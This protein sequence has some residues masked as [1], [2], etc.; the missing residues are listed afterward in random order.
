[1]RIGSMALATLV[2]ALGCGE[3]FSGGTG[4]SRGGTSGDGGQGGEGG[5]RAV[6]GDGVIQGGEECDDQN[7]DLGDGCEDCDV[8]C[9]GDNGNSFE[10]PTTH[11]CY[12]RLLSAYQW[13]PANTECTQDGGKLASLATQDEYNEI[14]ASGLTLAAW[15]GGND[16]TF[17]DEFVWVSGDPWSFAMWAPGN[18]YEGVDEDDCVLLNASFK[19]TDLNCG[20]SFVGICEFVPAGSSE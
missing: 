14:T 20:D 17:E 9:L 1:M 8:V 16:I 3:S 19:L 7:S 6:C 2:T 4:G 15:I 5:V 10:S 18:P 11:H 13:G 12:K